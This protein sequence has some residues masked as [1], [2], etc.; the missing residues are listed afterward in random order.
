MA[1]TLQSGRRVGK[2]MQSSFSRQMKSRRRVTQL[3]PSRQ[4]ASVVHG[5]NDRPMREVVEERETREGGGATC[6]AATAR[7][8]RKRG[9]SD[10]T[11]E[12]VVASATVTV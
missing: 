7:S 4:S 11:G 1:P 10:M 8:S 5:S 9:K 3:R 6:A 2:Q 12:K